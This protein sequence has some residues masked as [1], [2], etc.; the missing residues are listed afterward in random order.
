M[1][2]V[3][4]VDAVSVFIQLCDELISRIKEASGDEWWKDIRTLT[5]QLEAARRKLDRPV[6]RYANEPEW[7]AF[8]VIEAYSPGDYFG[9]G[10]EFH[11]VLDGYFKMQA[12][13]GNE[14]E[15]AGML[16]SCDPLAE[17]YSE[18]V[19]WYT[20]KKSKYRQVLS[21]DREE[22]IRKLARWKRAVESGL[23]ARAAKTMYNCDTM[24]YPVQC[25][26]MRPKNLSGVWHL[27]LK[28]LGRTRQ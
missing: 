5:E 1:K 23:L 17:S 11:K 24:T 3:R 26:R 15:G 28:L 14:I 19:L 9:M 2:G 6:W 10:A 25:L 22:A 16:L 21:T 12:D 20:E 4:L 27:T 7:P 13:G 18:S 8:L